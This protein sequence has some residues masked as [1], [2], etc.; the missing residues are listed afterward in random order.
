MLWGIAVGVVL[1]LTT[2]TADHVVVWLGQDSLARSDRSAAGQVAEFV[3]LI[4]DSG[5]AWAAAAVLAGWLACRAGGRVWTAAISG[6]LALIVGTLI[7]YGWRGELG[8]PITAYW[9]T[10]SVI[11]GPVLGLIGGLTRRPGWIGALAGLVVP[12]GAVFNILWLPVD[13]NSPLAVPITVL[14]VG[15]AAA[16]AA[17]VLFRAARFHRRSTIGLG[18]A[19]D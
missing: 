4:L 15:G 17:A 18:Q 11:L 19:S 10:A 9:L 6:S 14:I 7:F 2:S 1:G 5:W 13:P 8:S 16:A 3:S 12:A